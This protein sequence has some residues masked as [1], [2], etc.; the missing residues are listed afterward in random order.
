MI[1]VAMFDEINEGTAIF[2]CSDN[3][4]VDTGDVSFLHVEGPSDQYLWL[5][6]EAAKMLRHEIPLSMTLPERTPNKIISNE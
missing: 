4:P 3:P 6:G 1:Y 2:K 5:T